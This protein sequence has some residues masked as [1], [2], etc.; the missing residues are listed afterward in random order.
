MTP[1]VAQLVAPSSE[2]WWAFSLA[3]AAVLAIA[4]LLRQLRRDPPI[5]AEFATK[6]ELD[7]VRRQVGREVS[8]LRTEINAR[9]TGVSNKIDKMSAEGNERRV[10]AKHDFDM[11]ISELRG[12]IT[13]LSSDLKSLREAQTAD[14]KLILERL[15]RFAR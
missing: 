14:A 3:A 15:G 1:I 2:Q 6:R 4:V 8:E 13:T 7:G 10:E 11:R 12:D 9:F 5:E